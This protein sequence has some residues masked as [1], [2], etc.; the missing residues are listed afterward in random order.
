MSVGGEESSQGDSIRV[1]DYL[2]KNP[3]KKVEYRE[4]QGRHRGIKDLIG[5]G[6]RNRV[7]SVTLLSFFIVDYGSNATGLLRDAYEGASP[8]VHGRLNEAGGK[9]RVQYSVCLLREGRIHS[10]RVRLNQLCSAQDLDF[11]GVQRACTVTQFG[12]GK[13]NNPRILGVSR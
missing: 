11:K 2:N 10:V 8:R 9:M 12:R 5:G 6:G 13:K 7:N 3:A 1:D 4:N